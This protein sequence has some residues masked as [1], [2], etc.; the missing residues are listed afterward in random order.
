MNNLVLS[1][2]KPISFFTYRTFKMSDKKYLYNTVNNTVFEI[3]SLILD[4]LK[5]KGKSPN[6]LQ[7]IFK[8]KYTHKEILEAIENMEEGYIISTEHNKKVIDKSQDFKHEG[9]LSA[10]TLFMIQE[11]NLRCTY[12]Y[13]EEGEYHDKGRMNE[14]VAFAAVDYLLKRSKPGLKDLTLIFFGGEPLLNFSLI[15]KTVQYAL[16]KGKEHNKNFRFSMTTNG[17]LITPKIREFLEKN[18]ISVQISID[19]NEKTHNFNRFY[20]GGQGSYD[21]VV[22]RTKEM[23]EAN[24]L[25]ARGTVTPAELDLSASF[26]HLEH[27]GFNS[28]ALSPAAYTLSDKHYKILTKGMVGLVDKFRSLIMEMDYKQALKMSNVVGM[29]NKIHQGGIKSHFCGAA[30][31]FLAVDVRGN[32]YPCHRFV[33]EKDYALGNIFEMDSTA[34]QQR[35]IEDAHV[36]NRNTCSTCWARNICAGGCHH[37]NLAATKNMQEPPINYCKMTKTFIDAVMKLYVELTQ[38]QKQVIFGK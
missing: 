28:I 12:C 19:G 33:S 7:K 18:K 22:E 17:T 13:G 29:L 16:E 9:K 3:D 20:K 31:N 30:T 35:F 38:E 1:E 14:K 27:L 24:R 5:N 6:E 11:C 21:I 4:I 23:R 26:E 32:L 15:Q 36:K 10:L 34:N 2:D 25:T 37:E 8:G